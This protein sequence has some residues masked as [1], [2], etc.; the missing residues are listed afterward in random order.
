MRLVT[1]P[2]MIRIGLGGI[3]EMQ[4][5]D[6]ESVAI[7]KQKIMPSHANQPLPNQRGNILQSPMS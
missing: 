6:D 5:L 1:S 7:Y 2:V 4:L 3:R